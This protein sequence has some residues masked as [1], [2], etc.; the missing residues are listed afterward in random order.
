MTARV[1]S[2]ALSHNVNAAPLALRAPGGSDTCARAPCLPSDGLARRCSRQ[3]N[4]R[5]NHSEESV[6]LPAKVVGDVMQLM[7]QQGEAIKQLQERTQQQDQRI[8]QQDQSIKQLHE[9]KGQTQGQ[10]SHMIDSCIPLA[11][12]NTATQVLLFMAG[13]EPGRSRASTQMVQLLKDDRNREELQQYAESCFNG[14]TA[15]C[16]CIRR[17]DQQPQRHSACGSWML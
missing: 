8:K 16:H 4:R 9:F 6:S 13:T 5:Q 1:F 2:S 10:L 7:K 3:N 12:K 15:V 17:I 11:L 14:C